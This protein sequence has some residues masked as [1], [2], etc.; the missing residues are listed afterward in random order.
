MNEEDLQLMLPPLPPAI[1]P[2]GAEVTELSF[3][4]WGLK[5]SDAIKAVDFLR[6]KDGNFTVW[7]P[8]H[9]T[10]WVWRGPIHISKVNV[11]LLA[12]WLNK[13]YAA[14]DLEAVRTLY[15]HIEVKNDTIWLWEPDSYGD[16]GLGVLKLG[17][18]AFELSFMRAGLR[19]GGASMGSEDG[20][21][22][23]QWIIHRHD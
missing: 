23:E 7:T 18:D 14:I 12:T 17:D 1:M 6:G 3:T 2:P 16:S 11:E 10:H 8:G 20:H 13:G 5:G 22:L 15:E 4:V 19:R 21:L 9:L